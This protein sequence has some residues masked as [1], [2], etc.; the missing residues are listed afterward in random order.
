MGD[1]VKRVTHSASCH[2]HSCMFVG[3]VWHSSNQ[4]NVNLIHKPLS[5]WMILWSTYGRKWANCGIAK[6]NETE[7]QL[8]A[9]ELMI[10]GGGAKNKV[11]HHR[12]FHHKFYLRSYC[13]HT[14]LSPYYYK[15]NNIF[16]YFECSIKK[17]MVVVVTPLAFFWPW[18]DSCAMFEYKVDQAAHVHISQMG[19]MP[20]FPPAGS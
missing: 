16:L 6:W 14:D 13:S 15:N 1:S 17:K 3:K 9:N 5:D 4:L 8:H 18:G 7:Q 20:N 12:L 10:K 11:V 2:R 19:F